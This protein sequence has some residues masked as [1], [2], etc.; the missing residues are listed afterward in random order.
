MGYAEQV[1][2]LKIDTN[3]LH[4]RKTCQVFFSAAMPRPWQ[5]TSDM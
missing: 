3:I 2:E 5:V 1:P 4:L